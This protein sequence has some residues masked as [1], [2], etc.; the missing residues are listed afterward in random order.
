MTEYAPAPSPQTTA[1]AVAAFDFDGTLTNGGSVFPFLSALRGSATVLRA[2]SIL[3]PALVKAALVGGTAADEAKEELFTRL[4]GGLPVQEVDQRSAEF[5][6]EHLVRHL[7]ADTRRRMGVTRAR[8]A[9]GPRSTPAWSATCGRTAS[10]PTAATN[11][12]C[13]PTATAGATCA[14][15]PRPTTASMPAGWARSDACDGSPGWPT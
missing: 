1:S 2:V 13:G 5:A 7:R 10:S 14:C 12:S 4:L 3:S 15:W 11:R 8:T 9:G 6:H